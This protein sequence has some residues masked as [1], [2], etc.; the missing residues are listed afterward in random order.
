MSTKSVKV[1]DFKIDV[2]TN[3]ANNPKLCK[4]KSGKD[5][6]ILTNLS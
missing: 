5:N 4:P 6:Y 1:T 2:S 3:S